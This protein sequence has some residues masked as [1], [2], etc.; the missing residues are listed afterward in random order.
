MFYLG[1]NGGIDIMFLGDAIDI[2]LTK[3]HSDTSVALNITVNFKWC[4]NPPMN[5]I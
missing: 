2:Y 5:D 3:R 4:M 1:R